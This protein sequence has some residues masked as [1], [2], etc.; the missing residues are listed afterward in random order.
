[1]IIGDALNSEISAGDTI[2]AIMGKG[3]FFGGSLN[4]RNLITSNILGSG[5]SNK[6]QI[7][8]GYEP[9]TME[10]LK[11][12]RKVLSKV[13]YTYEEI[14]KHL[15]TLE[16]LKKAGSLKRDKEIHYARLI[17]TEEELRYNME[18]LNGEIS[19]LETTIVKSTGP[20]VKIRKTCHPNVR[21]KIGR[22][23]LTVMKNTTLPSSMK[24]RK[25]S[26]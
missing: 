10:K 26:R 16:K 7:T 15:M 5:A 11:N 9:R 22:L 23:F 14:K 8:V 25:R 21:I 17:A 1:M 13:K 19:M 12:L 3:R 4:A 18:E 2:D 6:T 20:L 24:K